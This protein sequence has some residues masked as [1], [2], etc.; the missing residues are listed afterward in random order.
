MKMLFSQGKS[1]TLTLSYDDGVVQDK[2][3]VEILDKHGIKCTF[4]ISA[5]KY[6]PGDTDPSYGK[7]TKSSAQALFENP[8]HEIAT[9]GYDHL[10]M[11]RLDGVDKIA[12]I[13]K[14]RQ[15]LETDFGRIVR[16]F[17]YPYGAFDADSVAALKLCG[18]A[19]ART[20]RST[21]KF[22]LPENWLQLHP[23]CHHNDERLMAL[24]KRFVETVHG[25]MFYLWGHSYEFDDRDNWHVIEEFAAYMG[26]REDIWYATNMEIY[27]Y[28]QAYRMLEINYDK[29]VVYNPTMTTLWFEQKG[30][31]YSIAPGETLHIQ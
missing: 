29:T 17:A 8:N 25:Q 16:G 12:Q 21:Y 11:T 15:Q 14:D 20:T 18:I 3:L 4:N 2:R 24:A 31:T 19:Y 13:A 26:G 23:T 9:H 28:V 5:G 7:M 27:A 1:K 6:T 30:N 10:H 22:E